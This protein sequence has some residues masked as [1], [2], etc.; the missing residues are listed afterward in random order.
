[1]IIMDIVMP[2]MDGREATKIIRATEQGRKVVIIAVTASALDEEKAE[3]LSLGADDFVKK[4][5]KESELL[6][7]ISIH[8]GIEYEYEEDTD[9]EVKQEATPINYAGLL[10]KLPSKLRADLE[11]ALVMGDVDDI[12]TCLQDVR[13]IDTQLADHFMRLVEVFDFEEI[14]SLFKK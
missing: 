9:V 8:A 12:S 6:E 13:K 4:P 3:I 11:K 5:F 1:V 7:S 14:L 2:V 10:L